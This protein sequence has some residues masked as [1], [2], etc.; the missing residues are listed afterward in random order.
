MAEE[1]SVTP[2][3][4]NPPHYFLAALVAEIALAFVPSQSALLPPPWHLAGGVLIVAGVLLAAVAARRFAKAGT[5]I[6][7]LTQ[8]T[9]LVTDGPF[10]MSRN[11]MYL[12]MTLT[13][14]GVALLANVLLPWFVLP[15]FVAILWFRFIRHEE[16]LMEKTFGAEYVAYRTRVRRWI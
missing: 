10:A 5:N 12:G 14:A 8:S 6:I 2:R 3:K 9:A 13:L 4:I 1:D 11:P 15:A 7:P 16:A